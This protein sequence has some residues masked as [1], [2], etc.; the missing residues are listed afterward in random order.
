MNLKIK[1]PILMIRRQTRSGNPPSSDK[2]LKVPQN[3]AAEIRF[4]CRFALS[5]KIAYSQFGNFHLIFAYINYFGTAEILL[6]NWIFTF[7]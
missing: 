3:F 6:T 1:F 5:Q 2:A 4:V 7:C